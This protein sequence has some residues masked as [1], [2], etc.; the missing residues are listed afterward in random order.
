MSVPLDAR[1]RCG[2]DGQPPHSCEYIGY[3]SARAEA[4][5]SMS[6]QPLRGGAIGSSFVGD[7]DLS[8]VRGPSRRLLTTAGRIAAAA[9]ARNSGEDSQVLGFTPRDFVIFGLP[10]RNPNT[11]LYVRRNGALTFTIT[12]G[13]HGVPYAQDR[14]LVIWLATVFKVC[15]SPE[16]NAIAFDSLRE[17]ARSLRKASSGQQRHR[18][19]TAFLRLFDATFLA[20]DSRP[21]AIRRERYQLMR[22]MRL[23]KENEARQPN[24]HTLWPNV[25]L[26]DPVFAND[27][28]T[29][30]VP[31]DFQSV[32]ALSD[33]MG[34]LSLYQ[35]EAHNSYLHARFGKPDRAVPV[36]GSSGLL[37]QIGCSV[38]E[39]DTRK[40]RATIRRWHGI[41]KRLWPDCPNELARGDTILIVR[42]GYAIK[43][44]RLPSP[45]EFGV[46]PLDQ[47]SLERMS[48][49][50]QR[51]AVDRERILSVQPEKVAQA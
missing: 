30:A 49:S 2:R 3:R 19:E 11:S 37:A 45:R 38:R 31:T 12:G 39:C 20:S 10:Y 22:R 17:V 6:A 16:T 32:L 35:F 5:A 42:A 47:L 51:P 36:L 34:P 43:H 4:K 40:A 25:L 33:N 28:R 13:T 44:G 46:R 1:H 26:Y 41:V 48:E 23:W 18:I 50:H 9:A 15:G 27:I 14:L 7:D 29:G 24:Q 8:S 21:N